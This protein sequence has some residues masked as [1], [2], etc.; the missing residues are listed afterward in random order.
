MLTCLSPLLGR[1]NLDPNLA[2]TGELSGDVTITAGT[3]HLK[4][5][6]YNKIL[7]AISFVNL[8]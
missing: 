7:F 5:A 4:I 3:G 6:E 8:K 2:E 1:E